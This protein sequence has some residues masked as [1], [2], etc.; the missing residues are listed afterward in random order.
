MIHHMTYTFEEIPVI[1]NGEDLLASGDI[2]VSY[3]IFERDTTV[4][5]ILP[6]V[7][8]DGFSGATIDLVND[9]GDMTTIYVG[10][11]SNLWEQII[12]GINHDFVIDEISIH[13]DL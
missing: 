1:L 6:D 9:N 3:Q 2:T 13:E 5:L 7:E 10:I 11:N 4:G 12:T 8:I